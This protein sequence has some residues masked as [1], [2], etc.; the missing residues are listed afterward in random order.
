MEKK[1]LSRIFA[2]IFIA[3]AMLF[4]AA[5]SNTPNT[6]NTNNENTNTQTITTTTTTTPEH[7]SFSD[8]LNSADKTIKDVSIR[9]Y[10]REEQVPVLDQR[11]MT[12]YNYHF[13]VVD[14][15][16]NKVELSFVDPNS[17]T[18][19]ANTELEKYFTTNETTAQAY[20]ITGELQWN[21]EK[22]IIYVK[23]LN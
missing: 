7:V 11:N 1:Y 13:Y 3:I 6:G 15:D 21:F 2:V 19:K 4:I 5:C 12:S 20:S 23:T 16:N 8:V 18:G 14:D 17:I 22:P 10:L 9:G